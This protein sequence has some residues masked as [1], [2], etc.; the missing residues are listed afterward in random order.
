MRRGEVRGLLW[1][2]IGDGVITVCHNWIDGEG[3]KAPK[4]KGGAVR[5]NKRLVP[6]PAS[7]ALAIEAVRQI[8]VNPAP[9]RFVFEGLR[10][11]GEPL[12]NNFFRRAL[13]VELL[14]IGINKPATDKNGKKAIDDA[15]QRRRNITF[16]GLR[17]SYITLGRIAGISD[18]EIQA[19]AGHKSGAMMERYSHGAQA[20]DFAVAREKLE[21]AIGG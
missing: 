4:C 9:D 3:V 7:V 6:F 13:A 14:V 12:G 21:R 8:S 18:I 16:H 17:H 11:P 2:D 1:G 5:E 20:L 10:R 19:L 15:E